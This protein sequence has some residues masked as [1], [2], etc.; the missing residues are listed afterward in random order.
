MESPR[1]YNASFQASMIIPWD[2][3]LAVKDFLKTQT[4]FKVVTVSISS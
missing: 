3:Y 2:V 4:A 1:K